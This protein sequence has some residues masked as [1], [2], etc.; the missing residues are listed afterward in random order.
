[1]GILD[2]LVSSPACIPQW[3]LDEV[4]PAYEALG[5]RKFEVFT[6]WCRSAVSPD[7]DSKAIVEK[8][9]AHGMQVTSL[10]L[11]P[12]KE[13]LDASIPVAVQAARLAQQLGADVVLFKAD[14][15]ANYIRGAKLFL[16]AIEKENIHVTPVLQ[17]HSG[18]AISTLEDYREVIDGINDRRMKT[19]LE[20]GHFQRV[21]VSW[22]QGVELLGDSI[23]L[24]H[25][26]EIREGKSVP[27]GEGDVDFA[28][29][30][31]YLKGKRYTGNIVVE[32]E[33]ETRNTDP[34]R[35]IEC[36]KDAR[37][38]IEGISQ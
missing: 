34:Q 6:S 37:D 16:D 18:T 14:T 26:N 9:K 2:Q 5:F 7:A 12:L 27:Y 1:M 15:R 33:L 25:I 20:V 28:G 31:Q 24:V 17:N 11:P 19:L 38:Y 4:L 8:M 3:T 29:L 35:T 22:R 21:G 13:D 36:L 32:L 10:H 30:F 23:A